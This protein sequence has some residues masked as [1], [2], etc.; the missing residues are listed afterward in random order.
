MLLR[1]FGH[2]KGGA[3]PGISRPGRPW[4]NGKCQSFIQMRGRNDSISRPFRSLEE[5]N[6]HGKD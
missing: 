3:V 4:E 5:R 6:N 1:L 2:V